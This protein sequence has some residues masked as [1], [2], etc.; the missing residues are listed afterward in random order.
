VVRSRP[1]IQWG[2]FAPLT[3]WIHY[4]TVRGGCQGVFQN[5]LKNFFAVLQRLRFCSLR[6]H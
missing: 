3:F 5:S 1:F 2:L 4:T 6:A